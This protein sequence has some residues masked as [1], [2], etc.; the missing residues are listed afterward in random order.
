[1]VSPGIPERLRTDAAGSKR[2][3]AKGRGTF[4]SS[5]EDIPAHGGDSGQIIAISALS[6]A[7]FPTCIYL[8]HEHRQKPAVFQEGSDSLFDFFDLP[9]MVVAI[10]VDSIA[11]RNNSIL[12]SNELSCYSLIHFNF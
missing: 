12:L 3:S 11:A 7:F 5:P 2:C 8:F 9:L 1:M 6:A 10:S 4:V